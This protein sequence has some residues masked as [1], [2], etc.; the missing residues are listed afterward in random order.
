MTPASAE[1]HPA[2]ATC[3]SLTAAEQHSRAVQ[4]DADIPDTNQQAKYQVICLSSVLPRA[5]I[6]LFASSNRDLIRQCAETESTRLFLDRS[7]AK[8]SRCCGTTC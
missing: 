6:E 3:R 4:S 5:G 1:A 8:V 2:D 7:R